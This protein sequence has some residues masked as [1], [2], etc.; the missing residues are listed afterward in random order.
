MK[1]LKIEYEIDNFSGIINISDWKETYE[2]LSKM[3]YRNPLR[4]KNFIQTKL[5]G[6]YFLYNEKKEIIYI[7]K[8]T[9]CIRGRLI[10]HLFTECSTYL[11]Y[12]YRHR[13]NL[14][15]KESIYFSYVIIDNDFIHLVEPYLIN[16]YKPVYNSQFNSDFKNTDKIIINEAKQKWIDNMYVNL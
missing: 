9:N 16:K 1:G 6:C 12:S 11:D 3:H 4:P 10:S 2:K 5:K 15:Q 8:S 7:G 13:H 14:K